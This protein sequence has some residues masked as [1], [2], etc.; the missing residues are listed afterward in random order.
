MKN[1]DAKRVLSIGV[2]ILLLFHG[3][4]NATY[5]VDSIVKILQNYNVPF[6]EYLVYALFLSE[7]VA[8]ILLLC[9]KFINISGTLIV[10]NI[11]ITIFLVHIDH[12]LEITKQGAW[13][14]EVPILY[15]IIGAILALWEKESTLN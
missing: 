1:H 12:L 3:V 9:N 4:H 7:L 14:V 10:I 13:S 15:L 2:A 11:S 6:A 8:P 5:G